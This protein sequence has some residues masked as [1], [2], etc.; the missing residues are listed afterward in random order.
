MSDTNRLRV[1]RAERRMSQ[2]TLAAVTR[3][4]PTRVWKIENG[5]VVPAPRERQAIASAL[6]TSESVVWPS[7]DRL[8]VKSRETTKAA[9]PAPRYETDE[10]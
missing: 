8:A 9:P 6:G 1:I 5:H 3:I 4:H 7:A 2:L 10:V